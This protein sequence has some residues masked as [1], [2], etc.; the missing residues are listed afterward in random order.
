MV[1]NT[2]MGFYGK[3]RAVNVLRTFDI[4]DWCSKKGLRTLLVLRIVLI[5]RTVTVKRT[6]VLIRTFVVIGTVMVITYNHNQ[7]LF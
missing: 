1:I 4:N 2:L 6:H 7:A 3:K 5:L